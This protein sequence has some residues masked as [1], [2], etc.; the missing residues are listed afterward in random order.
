MGEVVDRVG[1]R[2][3]RSHFSLKE[4]ME[5]TWMT[6]CGGEMG[7]CGE[8]GG[9][10]GMQLRIRFSAG[11]PHCSVRSCSAATKWSVF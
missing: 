6:S 1:R 4:A 9:L 3:E 10:V 2:V 11:N 7:E 8:G 5:E